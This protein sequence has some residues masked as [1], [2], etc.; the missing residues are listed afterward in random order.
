MR[1]FSWPGESGRHAVRNSCPVCA[2]NVFG[3]PEV[4]GD[5]VNIYAGTLDD[6]SLFQ[7]QIAIFR[8]SRRDW[9]RAE[10]PGFDGLPEGAPPR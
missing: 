9:D 3:A 10:T 1:R 4:I 7:A 2:S 5:T 6:P 8:R